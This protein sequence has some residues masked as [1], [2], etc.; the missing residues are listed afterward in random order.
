LPRWWE[1]NLDSRRSPPEDD[2]WRPI[3]ASNEHGFLQ[4]RQIEAT[5]SLPRA[6]IRQIE[7]LA[8]LDLILPRLL[9]MTVAVPDRSKRQHELVPGQERGTHRGCADQ[10][11]ARLRPSLPI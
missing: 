1:G 8:Y 4:E 11:A 9:V 5:P 3:R 7:G 2:R 10:P 6:R